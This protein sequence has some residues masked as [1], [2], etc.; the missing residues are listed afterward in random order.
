MKNRLK[1][2]TGVLVIFVIVLSVA[3]G[4]LVQNRIELNDYISTQLLS[5]VSIISRELENFSEGD[6]EYTEYEVDLCMEY[7]SI[8]DWANTDTQTHNLD[9]LMLD[10]RTLISLFRTSSKDDDKAYILELLKRIQPYVAQLASTEKEVGEEKN[11]SMWQKKLQLFNDYYSAND[12][13][14]IHLAIINLN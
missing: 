12:Y 4:Y 5:S 7:I 2:V 1:V 3:C 8:Y 9:Y 11:Q 14:D 13:T 10:I 6:S